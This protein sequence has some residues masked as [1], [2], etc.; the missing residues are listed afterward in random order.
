MWFP[1]VRVSVWKL[2]RKTLKENLS[3]NRKMQAACEVCGGICRERGG[4]AITG[5]ARGDIFFGSGDDSGARAGNIQ[6]AGDV[7]VLLPAEEAPDS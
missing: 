5:P 1:I 2:I 4:S 6:H 3:A 7:V